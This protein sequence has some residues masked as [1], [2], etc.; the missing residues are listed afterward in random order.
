[1]KKTEE[2]IDEAVCRLDQ[3]QRRPH[4]A[5]RRV[6]R[7]GDEAVDLIDRQHHGAEHHG[8]FEQRLGLLDGQPLRL[9]QLDHRRDVLAANGV[10]I[11]DFDG[12]RQGNALRRGDAFDRLALAE[13]HAAGD[14]LFLADDGGARTVRGSSPSGSTMRLTAERAFWMSW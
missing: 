14:A 8:V 3:L 5:R 4:R 7:A 2:T 13:Q 11:E 9:A 1:M 12:R 6:D 10:G